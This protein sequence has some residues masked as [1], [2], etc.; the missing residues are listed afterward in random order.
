MLRFFRNEIDEKDLE[1]DL[2]GKSAERVVCG[3]VGRE[4]ISD[5]GVV[6][7]TAIRLP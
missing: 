5:T 1:R 6:V 7:K 4:M 2:G 3:C